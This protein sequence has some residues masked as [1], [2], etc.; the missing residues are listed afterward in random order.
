MEYSF[1]DAAKK[2]GVGMNVIRKWEK[3]WNFTHTRRM[4]MTHRRIYT[5]EDLAKLADFRL[6]LE[7]ARTDAD[8]RPYLDALGAEN[9]SAGA[10]AT[11]L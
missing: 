9:R 2:L 6:A 3:R 1:K 8:V 4:L 10:S 5:D 7:T 11:R